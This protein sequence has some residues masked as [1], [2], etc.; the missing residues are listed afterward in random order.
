MQ[1]I[2][3][4]G[5]HTE[6]SAATA[7]SPKKICVLCVTGRQ[8]L[9]IGSHNVHGPQVVARESKAASDSTKATSKRQTRSAGMRDGASRCN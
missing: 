3:E 7:Q 1:R 2:F 9:P 4:G 8:Q 5:R 6:V